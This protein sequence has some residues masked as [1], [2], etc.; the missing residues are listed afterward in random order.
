MSRRAPSR[1]RRTLAASAAALAVTAGGGAL[2]VATAAPAA[3]VAPVC[4]NT[5]LQLGSRGAEV[6]YLQRRLH[7]TADGVFG[8][9]TEA[10]VIAYQKRHSLRRPNGI[11]G[12]AT[13]T[14]LGMKKICSRSSSSSSS[15][16]SKVLAHAAATAR[17]ARYV[18]G[19]TGPK[20]FDCSGYTGYVYRKAGKVLPRTSSQQHA[21]TTRLSR[22]Q[23][24]PGDLFFVHSSSGRVYHVGIVGEGGTWWEAS[25]PRT[26][27]GNHKPWSSRISYG[28]VR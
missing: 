1:L 19:A 27:V 15:F 20:S 23:V 13:W 7:I 10:H 3:A 21:A 11:V 14:S 4:D 28:R 12:P 24:R 6:V 25:S 5:V 26:G 2:T 9:Q 16:H 17:G 18:Y 8:R 22:S